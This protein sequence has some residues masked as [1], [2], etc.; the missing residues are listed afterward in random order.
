MKDEASEDIIMKHRHVAKYDKLN[1]Q[2]EKWPF[3]DV[4]IRDNAVMLAGELFE[5]DPVTIP[6]NPNTTG[7]HTHR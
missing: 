6:P 5:S 4:L 7:I 3:S 2:Q 1:A